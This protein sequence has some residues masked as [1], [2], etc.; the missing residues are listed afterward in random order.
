MSKKE[1]ETKKPSRTLSSKVANMANA[2]NDN[3]LAVMLATEM[4]KQREHFKED[5]ASLIKTSLAPIQASI[6]NFHEM[7]DTLGRRVA[8]VETTAGDNFDA[9]FKAEKAINELQTLNAALVDR[10]DDLENR[11]RRV[12]LHIIN[13][14]E[15]SE[16]K[17]DSD[18]MT[19]VSTLLKDKMGNLFTSPPELERAHRAMVQKPKKGQPPRPIIVA[20]HRFQERDRALRWA[21]QNDVVYEGNTLRFYPDFSAHLSK[22]RAAF[23]N[24]KAALYQKGIQFRLLYPASL[25]VTYGG[26]TLMF[27]TPAEAETFYSQKVERNL[28]IQAVSEQED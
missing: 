18:M 26:E 2:A 6:A 14:P 17:G 22:K 5:M 8:A 15:D 4:E 1:S 12:N 7:V 11:S 21:R 16:T 3:D 25:C 24:V 10:I 27:E 28:D 13:V 23:K 19:F 20:F 9:L